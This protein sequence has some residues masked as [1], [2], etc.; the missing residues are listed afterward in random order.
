MRPSETT[1]GTIRRPK[2]SSGSSAVAQSA[3]STGRPAEP[4][5]GDYDRLLAYVYANGENVNVEMMRRGWTPYW[6]EYVESRFAVAF[7]AAERAAR[8]ESRGLWGMGELPR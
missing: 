6:T 7:E 3:W 5:R 2:P 1:R 4:S 8:S